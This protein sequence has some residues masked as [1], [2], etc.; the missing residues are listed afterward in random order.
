MI[1]LHDPLIHEAANEHMLPFDIVRG[2][3]IRE[4]SGDQ[5]AF[6]YE[7]AY[8]RRYIVDDPLTVM[9]DHPHAVAQRYGPLAACSFGLMQIMLETA[10]EIGF[11]G[12]PEDLFRPSVNLEWGC[13]LLKK[14]VDQYQGDIRKAL[15]VYNGGPGAVMTGPPYRTEAYVNAVFLFAGRTV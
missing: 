8:F 1:T 14:L 2:V 15:A 12:R 10:L 6:R 4:S 9:N 13:T 11:E 3:V 7:P 5:F